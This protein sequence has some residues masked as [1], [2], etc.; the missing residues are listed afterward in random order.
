ML[1]INFFTSINYAFLNVRYY[2]IPLPTHGEKI[3]K[4][5]LKNN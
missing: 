3:S 5:P 1:A 4:P 2:L